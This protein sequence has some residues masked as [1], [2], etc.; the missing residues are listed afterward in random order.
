MKKTLYYFFTIPLLIILTGC[1]IKNKTAITNFEECAK[2]GNAIMESYPR[3]CR[4][5]DGRLFVEELSPAE[6]EK[7]KPPINEEPTDKFC[8]RSTG[9]KC[10]IDTDCAIGG[11]SS[12]VCHA[13]N[14]DEPAFTT[15]EYQSCYNA[16]KYRVLCK[17]VDKECQWTKQN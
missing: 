7:L 4:T 11:C 12:Q 16:E 8:G 13:K 17:C 10:L 5:T 15:C 1:L 2:A 9:E 6:K 14:G 3:Q